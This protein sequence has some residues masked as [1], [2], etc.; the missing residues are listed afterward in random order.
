[1]RLITSLLISYAIR[2]GH[3]LQQSA[4]STQTYD[5]ATWKPT[6]GSSDGYPNVTDFNF[7]LAGGAWNELSHYQCVPVSGAT[8]PFLGLELEAN[9]S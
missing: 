1:M 8:V 6:P 9:P 3:A 4:R 7:E 2:A 5:P